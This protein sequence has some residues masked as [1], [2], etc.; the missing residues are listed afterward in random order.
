VIVR[1]LIRARHFSAARAE[2]V[3][4]RLAAAARRPY[5]ITLAP[6]LIGRRSGNAWVVGQGDLAQEIAFLNTL[7]ITRLDIASR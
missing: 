1:Y 4:K 7:H 3:A 2:R 6:R 5:W